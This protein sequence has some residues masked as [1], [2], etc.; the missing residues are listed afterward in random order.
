MGKFDRINYLKL[1]IFE[2]QKELELLEREQKMKIEIAELKNSYNERK[3]EL[4]NNALKS[5]EYKEI[6][7]E[8]GKKYFI[9]KEGEVYSETKKLSK[10]HMKNGY[11]YVSIDRKT[12]LLH[13]VVWEV[14]NGE[15]PEG[16]EIDHINTDRT[17]NR[18]ENLRLVTSKENKNNPLTIEKYKI[19]N[20][21][22][23][24]KKAS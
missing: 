15:I 4:V 20:R 13:R 7:L 23:G 9:T 6:L 14:F 21:G 22:K 18:I 8:N 2:L 11:D 1:K 24:K 17:D 19:S 3:K 5:C 16:M 10:T 12:K